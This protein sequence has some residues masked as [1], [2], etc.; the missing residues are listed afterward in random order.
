ML[1]VSTDDGR[2]KVWSYC[3]SVVLAPGYKTLIVIAQCMVRGLKAVGTF[4]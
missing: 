2:G 4:V 1:A 3:G